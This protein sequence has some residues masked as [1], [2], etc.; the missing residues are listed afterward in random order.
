MPTASKVF[1]VFVSS[2][3]SDMR[4]ERAILQ[5]EVFPK[6]EKLCESKGARFQAVDLRWGVTES[7][8]M[9]QK[10]MDI[11]LGEIKRCQ[12]VSPM[13][14]FIALIGDRY[15]WQPIPA[16]ISATEM[17]QIMEL[18]TTDENELLVK[19]YKK[20]ENAVPAEYILQP[21]SGPYLEYPVWE[22][23]EA[24]I[25]LC[26]RKAV[27]KMDWD[28][29]Q[30]T[31]YFASATHQEILSGALNPPQVVEKPEEHVFAYVRNIS[32][33]PEDISAKDFIDLDGNSRDKYCKEKLEQLKA[34]LK[35]KLKDHYCEY[36]ASWKDSKCSINDA[37]S[38]ANKA[39]NDLAETIKLQLTSETS[40]NEIE[41][42]LKIHKQFREQLTENFCGRLSALNAISEYI[43][44][45]T[46]QQVYS[47]IG[48]SGSGKSSIMAKAALQFENDYGKAPFFRF[49]GISA[50][51]SNI[52]SFIGL[53][54]K[55][56]CAVFD[57]PWETINAGFKDL[58]EIRY[59]ILVFEK[60]LSL[61]TAEKQIVIF[62]DAL[63]QFSNIEEP[64]ML[65]WLPEKLPQHVKIICSALPC[66][67]PKLSNAIIYNLTELPQNDA[68]IILNKWLSN[69]GRQLTNE[70]YTYLISQFSKNG[71]SIYLKLAF[72]MA[73]RWKSYQPAFNLKPDVEGIINDFFDQLE[74]EHTRELVKNIV[75]Y[76]LCARYSGLTENEIL[77]ILFFDKSFK[78]W[79]VENSHIDHR[80]EIASANKIPIVVW[81]RLYFDMEPYLSEHD[82]YGVPVITFFH[83]QFIDVLKKRYRLTDEQQ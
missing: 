58:T 63:D 24:S 11:C 73:K 1:R 44:N 55:Q 47:I 49:A 67:A 14:N 50:N 41:A 61:A 25:R 12:M 26:L 59:L 21:R 13:P 31:R 83:R 69:A 45:K 34:G 7:S 65:D 3:F 71:F 22:K 32:D 79:F 36:P 23:T 15:G 62:I 18:L 74:K 54:C 38:F 10:T 28:D 53:L 35:E 29:K 80:S 56:I 64:N 20:D 19:W 68:E 2:T 52:S 4:E 33:M 77:E 40:E 5:N 76:M 57:V 81:S 8:Q 30:K 17:G 27:A 42:E 51:S 16:T 82:A 70:Q 6:L 46:S 37:T 75:C 66:L 72:E 48:P 60:C 43:E 78:S 39:Y 9:D